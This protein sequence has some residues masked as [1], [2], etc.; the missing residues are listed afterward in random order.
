VILTTISDVAK[1]AGV[2]LKTV[3]RV[4][5]GEPTVRPATRERVLKFMRQLD[6]TPVTAART[7]RTKRTGLIGVLTSA[8]TSAPMTPDSAGL[9]AVN[10]LKGIQKVMD[11]SGM[12]MM[13]ADTGENSVNFMRLTQAFREHQ[14][15]GILYVADYHQ[16]F[17]PPEIF[18]EIPTVLVNCFDKK[19]RLSAVV[20]DDSEGGYRAAEVAFSRG[21]Q[22]IGL[23]TL[24]EIMVASKQ[25]KLGYIRAHKERNSPIR[26][27]LISSVGEMGDSP[28][29]E[30]KVLEKIL[31][32]MLNL[33]KPPTAICCG[34]DKMAMSVYMQLQRW[35]I[36]IPEQ[37]SV[38]GFDDYT[39]ISEL[40]SPRLTTVK[41]PYVQIGEHAAELL[42]ERIK[43]PRGEKQSENKVS[44]QIGPVVWRH[45][46]KD[47]R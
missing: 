45:S 29:I 31:K 17:N 20:P 21:H 15:E 35:G 38:I 19:Q 44:H 3:S 37:I 1:A 40:L 28:E 9:P 7:M 23:L 27:E 33:Q 43:K 42:I 24:P 4:L 5:N 16:Q 14:V 11:Q 39:L 12:L 25:R 41:L 30:Q 34:N 13:V 6:Y 36:T 10:L 47:L 32:E 18:L 26:P 46:V 8:I 22:H 2:S